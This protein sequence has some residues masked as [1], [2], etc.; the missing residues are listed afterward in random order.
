[1]LIPRGIVAALV[2]SGALSLA[3]P[4][5][6]VAPVAAPTLAAGESI[7]SD[8]LTVAVRR[9]TL[10]PTAA[11]EVWIISPSDGY[12]EPAPGIARLAALSIIA[13]K[14]DGQSLRDMV[15]DDG[16]QL[17]VSVFPSSTEISVL[18]PANAADQLADAL[19]A[20]VLHPAIDAAGFRDGKLRLAE[21]QAVAA[22]EPDVLLRDGI[23]AQLFSN[24]PF[25]AS[26]YGGPDTLR[27]LNM[28]DAATYATQAY[29]PS[30]EI[31]VVVGGGLDEDALNARIANAAPPA[32]L[33]GSLPASS[34]AKPSGTTYNAGFAD[35]GGVALGWIGP[36][37]SDERT[38]TAMDFISDYLTR[39]DYGLVAKAVADADP[40]ADF[41]GQFIT[42]RTAGVFYVTVTGGKRSAD[43]MAGVVRAAMKPL[44]D[45]P[46][47]PQEFSRALEAFRVHTLRDTQT[48]QEL[49]DNYGWYFAQGAP[50]Y[51]PSVTDI[52]LNGDYYG[53]AA[54]LTAQ[55]V[56]EAAKTYLGAT[57]VTAT[58]A[59]RPQAPS[60][61]SMLPG[62]Q[63]HEGGA[64]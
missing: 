48:P 4:A 47:P 33:G 45:G 43:A 13:T 50:A 44:L 14:V 5:L 20:R 42:L 61:T 29:V 52:A 27:S 18:A 1:M 54:A 21:Q 23:F 10:S 39:P 28:S 55:A 17:M 11:L 19:V 30:N 59:P 31:V 12:G 2:F 53:Q 24:G 8:G 40:Q 36:S 9:A 56:Y 7:L 57:A 22:S 38:S 64:R 60:T 51:A 32:A 6:A 16:G 41:N 15:R 46:L 3:L 63:V 35:T 49:A 37:V 26:T 62:V 34:L 25:H 58:V